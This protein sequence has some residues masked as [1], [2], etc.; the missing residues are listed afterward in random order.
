MARP[1][2]GSS[3]HWIRTS[4][5]GGS[6]ITANGAVGLV[7]VTVAGPLRDQLA[8]YLGRDPERRDGNLVFDLGGQ[9]TLTLTDGG[10]PG[11]TGCTVAVRNLS[12]TA[13]L[14]QENLIPF[15]PAP[16][17]DLVVPASF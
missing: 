6:W 8:T 5:A 3:P 7:D 4:K 16:N 17:G 1:G 15:E 12:G 10:R 2:S 13:R 14:L 9:A 11:V